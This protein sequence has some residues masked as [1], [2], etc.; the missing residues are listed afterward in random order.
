MGMDSVWTFGEWMWNVCEP[1]AS[2]CGCVQDICSEW[3]EGLVAEHLTDVEMYAADS[4][5]GGFF[6][7]LWIVCFVA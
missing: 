2:A 3:M 1:V 7:D 5:S 6:V 4:F